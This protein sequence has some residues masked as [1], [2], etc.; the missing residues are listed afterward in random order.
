MPPVHVEEPTRRYLR[1]LMWLLVPAAFF[2]GFDAELRALLL[3]Q[4]QK[5]F[6][7][8]TAALGIANIPIGAGQFVAFFCVRLAD[9]LGRRPIL[10]VSLLGYALFT[11]LTASASSV[12]TFA[13]YQSLGQV[14][15]GTEY[16]LAVLV[17]AEEMPPEHR[18][19]A[20]GTLL[21]AAPLG[22][23]ATAALLGAGLQHTDLGWRAFYLVGVVPLLA[24]GLAR[25]LL[26]ETTAFRRAAAGG[27]SRPRVPLR[28]VLARPWRRLVLALGALNFLE[29]VPVTAGAGWWVYYAE[30]ERHLSTGLVAIDLG[31]AY[32]LGTLGYYACGRAIDRF[33]RRPVTAT[34]LGLGAVFGIALFQSAG[35]AANFVLLVLAVFFGLGVGPA[36]SALSAECFPTHVRAQAG[37]VV[38]NGFANAGELLGPALVGVLGARHG[39]IGSIGDT[40]TILALLMPMAIVVVWRFVPETRGSHL[41]PESPSPD[42]APASAPGAGEGGAGDGGGGAAGS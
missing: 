28:E 38:G 29:K 15:L 22:A 5:A 33:G 9:R 3:P 30:K 40:V 7:V 25:R 14:C 36:L 21:V 4:L 27:R 2:N 26:H 23:V 1:L 17:V 32:A 42:R 16:A 8:G 12:V 34:Y 11:G 10:L 19:R 13:L 37:A 20:I 35:E 18:G 41:Y 31:T 39:L 24:I 6:G